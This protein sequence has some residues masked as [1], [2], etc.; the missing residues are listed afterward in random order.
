[1]TDLQYFPP[2]PQKLMFITMAVP[3]YPKP[4][5]LQRVTALNIMLSQANTL[6]AMPVL[7][8]TSYTQ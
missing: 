3:T 4:L 7:T 6:Q 8:F 5:T 2:Y 1:M